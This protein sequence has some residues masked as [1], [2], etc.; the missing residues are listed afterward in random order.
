MSHVDLASP[1]R[2]T[3]SLGS[4]LITAPRVWFV[5]EARQDSSAEPLAP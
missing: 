2:S 1:G 4:G 5:A 3:G